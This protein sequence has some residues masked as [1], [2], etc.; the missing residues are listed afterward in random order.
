V[1][2]TETVRLDVSESSAVGG[3][4]RRASDLAQS[5]G[6]DA[7]GVGRVA[8][9]VTEA[10]S[11]LVKHAGGGELLLHPCGAEGQLDLLAL[12][13]GRGIEDVARATRDGFSTG[14][15]PGTGLGAIRRNS[16][17]MDLY[18]RPGGG[19]GLFARL[20]VKAPRP[21]AMEVGA[22]SIRYPGEQVCGDGFATAEDAERWQ[23]L[24]VDGLGHG[25]GAVFRA[26]PMLGLPELLSRMH[27]AL[28]P[29]RGAAV[30]V[31]E[32]DRGRELLRFAGIGNV[33]GSIVSGGQ[34]RSTVSLYGT[35]GHDARRFQEFTYPWPRGSL[36]VL[37]SDGL[38]ARWN[39]EDYPGLGARHPGLIAGILYRD[40][41]RA[42]DDATVVVLRGPS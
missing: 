30:G 10:A 29:T 5:L 23:V 26:T 1:E 41:G 33:A 7:E 37:H 24:V 17:V 11:N 39:L 14:G 25:L 15:T 40:F 16:T 32:I 34:S 6:F 12:D 21:R 22:V 27:R 42:R 31:A 18:T 8:L 35:M 3:A 13:R 9:V 19:T 38:S 2:V 28:A 20:C 36:F 4:R